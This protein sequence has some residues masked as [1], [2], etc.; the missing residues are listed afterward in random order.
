MF[1]D[2]W[3][4]D[5][6]S[7]DVQVR[8]LI[9]EIAADMRRRYSA[10]RAAEDSR[11]VVAF[12]EEGKACGCAG[13]ELLLLTV[14]GRLPSS[15]SERRAV[16]TRLRPHMS[17]LAVARSARRAGLGRALVQACEEVALGWGCDEQTLF[18]D[19]ENEAATRLYTSLGYRVVSALPAEK[20]V[21]RKGQQKRLAVGEAFAWVSTTN[22]F[23]VKSDLGA[24]FTAAQAF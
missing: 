13:V 8:Q 5:T 9:D 21:P 7:S 20:P 6:T 22:A 4:G 12:D 3:F 10:Q 23:L 14:D 18:V 11:L 16:T 24:P 15:W 2:A 19:C 1:I 17:N